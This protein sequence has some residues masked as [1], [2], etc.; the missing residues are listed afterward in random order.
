MTLQDFEAKGLEFSREAGVVDGQHGYFLQHASRLY[1]TCKQFH[2]FDGNL[3]DVLEIGPFFG[4]V[5][6]FLRPYASSYTVLEGNDPAVQPLKPVYE[7]RKINLRLVDLFDLFGPTRDTRHSL[8]LAD[9]SFDT[10]LCWAT[11][12]HFNF[13]P[14][15]FVRELRRVLKPG[16]RVFITVPNKASMPNLAALILG[17]SEPCLVEA[18]YTF[19]DYVSDGKKAF[20]GFHWREYTA[21]EL[22]HLFSRAGFT[23]SRCDTSVAFQGTTD[24]SFKRRARRAVMNGLCK[25]L[26]RYA[27]EIRLVGQK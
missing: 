15:K 27:T 8:E 4:Y 1:D 17:W 23:I 10:I 7:K 2:L 6:C 24:T 13:N 9:A 22:R 21:P 3:G 26:P 19:E 12:E 25:L 20:Y 16:G 14:V 11:M 18:Y 5:P